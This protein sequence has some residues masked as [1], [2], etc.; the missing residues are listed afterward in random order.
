ME[1]AQSLID[2]NA[3][4]SLL[5]QGFDIIFRELHR[6]IYFAQNYKGIDFNTYLAV[7][8]S[9]E[10]KPW[11][12]NLKKSDHRGPVYSHSTTFNDLDNLKSFKSKNNIPYMKQFKV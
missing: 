3:T 8:E 1:R 7:I 6:Y 12:E 9:P 11:N 5:L 10:N 2:E 4:E